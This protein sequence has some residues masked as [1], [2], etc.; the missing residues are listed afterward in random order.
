MP[1]TSAHPQHTRAKCV[2]SRGP[3]TSLAALSHLDCWALHLE[4]SMKF[5]RRRLGSGT[6]NLGSYHSSFYLSK[7]YFNQSKY[8]LRGHQQNTYQARIHSFHES[9]FYFSHQASFSS[10]EHLLN[11]N[12][13][14]ASSSQFSYTVI[15]F[16]N[17]ASTFNITILINLSPKSHVP[18]WN[19]L[20]LELCYCPTPICHFSANY[21]SLL[22]LAMAGS[23]SEQAC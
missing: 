23:S 11:K 18:T 10:T 12:S 14:H 4:L 20:P 6:G 13:L 7:H 2:V 1:L 15:Y 17:P 19:G 3:F 9:N 5:G 8:Y 22:C 16:N 21:L